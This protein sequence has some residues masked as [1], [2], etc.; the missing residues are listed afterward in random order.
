MRC[1]GLVSSA[2]LKCGAAVTRLRRISTLM[3]CRVRGCRASG[4]VK[5]GSGLPSSCLIRPSGTTSLGDFISSARS[6]EVVSCMSH[7]GCSCSSHCCVTNDFH[8]S[9]D[10]HLSPRGH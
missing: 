9:N 2:S 4:T 6:S 7:V 3:T 1:D 5:S 10:S 8:H